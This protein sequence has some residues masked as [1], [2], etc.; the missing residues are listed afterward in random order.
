[1]AQLDQINMSKVF[2]NF[3]MQ[4]WFNLVHSQK[5]LKTF[6][7]SASTSGIVRYFKHHAGLENDL[8]Q[9]SLLEFDAA[10]SN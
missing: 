8:D 5:R 2:L 10:Y 3:K 9:I 6:L 4:M 7:L 1:M